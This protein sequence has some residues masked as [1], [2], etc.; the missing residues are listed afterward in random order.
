[1]LNIDPSLIVNEATLNTPRT[2][3]IERLQTS[4]LTAYFRVING[5]L[6]L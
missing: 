1:M 4:L 3:V 6:F 5:I 2:G